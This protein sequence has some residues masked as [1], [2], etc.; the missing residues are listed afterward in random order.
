MVVSKIRSRGKSSKSRQASRRVQAQRTGNEQAK[1]SIVRRPCRFWIHDVTRRGDRDSEART[2]LL[3]Q[4]R[5][6][7]ERSLCTSPESKMQQVL[8]DD[9][10][11][12]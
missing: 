10:A 12:P 8:V 4:T 2:D 9:A 11:A 7:R 5:S 6:A 3:F 1:V